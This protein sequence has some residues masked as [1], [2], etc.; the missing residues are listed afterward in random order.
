MG[1]S[2]PNGSVRLT[3]SVRM[4]LTMVASTTGPSQKTVSATAKIS[5]SGAT[6]SNDPYGRWHAARC[7]HRYYRS[8]RSCSRQF[9][10]R[11][12]ALDGEWVHLGGASVTRTKPVGVHR[13]VPIRRRDSGD[14]SN[15][16]VSAA[17][18]SSLVERCASSVLSSNDGAYSFLEGALYQSVS[19]K[20]RTSECRPERCRQRRNRCGLISSTF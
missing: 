10:G 13:R 5:G 3:G 2:K 20:L 9:A 19:Q 15:S 4:L 1:Q 17:V 8:R 18:E 14:V 16:V 12:P 7:A 6:H 11:R